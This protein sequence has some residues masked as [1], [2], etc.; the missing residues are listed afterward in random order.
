MGMRMGV[1]TLMATAL[2][3]AAALAAS[4]QN[5][6]TQ[7]ALSLEQQGHLAQAAVIWRQLLQQNPDNALA[8][9]HLGLLTAHEENYTAAEGYYRRALKLDPRMQGLQLDLGLALF[10]QGKLLEAAAPLKAAAAAMPGNLQPRLLLAMSYYG[11]GKYAEAVP[12]LRFAVQKAP[13]NMQ[14]R[15]VLAQSCLFAKQYQCTLDQYKQII[16]AQPNSAQAHMLAGEALDGL[17]RTKEAIQEFQNAAKAAP[18]Y[19]NVHFG[20]GYLY[21]T[22]HNYMDAA[23]Q[24]RQELNNVPDHVQALTYLGDTEMKLQKPAAAEKYLR[25]AVT[26]SG[27]TQLAWDDLGIL[28]ASQHKN[29][30]AAADFEHAIRLA[31][32]QVEAHWRLARLYLAE[33]KKTKAQ[34]EFDRVKAIH[35]K[36]DEGLVDQMRVV[37]GAAHPSP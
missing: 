26:I 27:A 2:L 17:K 6:T 12:W 28:M 36:K 1:R 14:L 16:L 24:F 25:R 9:A 29:E 35:Q 7:R 10:K 37:T 13:Q 33:G 3:C 31:P 30:E 32:N 15:G 4:A 23:D 34:A 11:A 21:W 8:C 18:T 20:L 5:S 22:Q 19:P